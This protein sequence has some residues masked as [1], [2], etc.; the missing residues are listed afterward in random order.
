M[1]QQ[2]E[3][4]VMKSGQWVG[5]KVEDIFAACKAA[6]AKGDAACVIM[7]H[8][9]EFSE[10]KFTLTDLGNLKRLLET[11]GWAS[12][13]FDAVAKSY[14][15]ACPT[16]SPTRAPTPVPTPIGGYPKIKEWGQ[17]GIALPV[18]NYNCDT[19]LY[20]RGNQWWQSCQTC[21]T[22]P[23]TTMDCEQHAIKCPNQASL[24]TRC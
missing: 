10:G 7:L 2:T 17:C 8:P 9:Q 24:H 3:T 5:N 4:A 15:P 11:N 12:K 16:A 13:T 1:P 6:F 23:A 20:C 14:V 19:G 21:T 22:T 18:V